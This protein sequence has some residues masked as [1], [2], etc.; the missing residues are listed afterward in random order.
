LASFSAAA[1][2]AEK[3]T[4]ISVSSAGGGL[5]TEGATFWTADRVEVRPN[6]RDNAACAVV[7]TTD[8]VSNAGVFE[9]CDAVMA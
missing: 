8:S 6:G 1:G 5:V 2:K 4:S 7:V 9:K 3:S